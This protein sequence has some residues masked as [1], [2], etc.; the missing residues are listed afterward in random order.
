M[1]IKLIIIL[2][3]GLTLIYIIDYEFLE[4]FCTAKHTG[5]R[6]Y[7]WG[8]AKHKNY[9]KDCNSYFVDYYKVDDTRCIITKQGYNKGMETNPITTTDKNIKQ[10]SWKTVRCLNESGNANADCKIWQPSDPGN[11]SIWDCEEF[12]NGSSN[13]SKSFGNINS[14]TNCHNLGGKNNPGCAATYDLN[15]LKSLNELGFSCVL[16]TTGKKIAPTKI[17]SNGEIICVK[18]DD[19]TGCLTFNSETDC[20]NNLF[21]VPN[22]QNPDMVCDTKNKSTACTNLYNDLGLKTLGELTYTTDKNV[23]SGTIPMRLV[24]NLTAVELP[25]YDGL[26]PI[27]TTSQTQWNNTIKDQIPSEELKYIKC[28]YTQNQTDWSPKPTT[29]T[30]STNP[31]ENFIQKPQPVDLSKLIDELKDAIPDI[32]IPGFGSGGG[33]GSGGNTVGRDPT[34]TPSTNK[35]SPKFNSEYSNLCYTIG[36][37]FGLFPSS[38]QMVIKAKNLNQGITSAFTS[39]QDLNNFA[40]RSDM[41]NLFGTSDTDEPSEI[42]AKIESILNKYPLQ[43]YCCILPDTGS[44]KLNI[45]VPLDPTK[46]YSK[47][48]YDFSSYGS[49]LQTIDVDPKVCDGTGY[50][51]YGIDGKGSMPSGSCDDF[52]KVNCANIIQ[53]LKN[54]KLDTL[55]NIL[56]YAP[57]CACF[58]PSTYYS[59]EDQLIYQNVSSKCWK[60]G[61]KD[62]QGGGYYDRDS[63]NAGDCTAVICANFITNFNTINSENFN[64]YSSMVNECGVNTSTS[65]DNT[66]SGTPSDKT[67]TPSATTTPSDTKTP[68]DTSSDTKT[69]SDT[70]SDTK[71]TSDTTSDTKTSSDTKTPSDTSSDTKTPSDNTSGTTTSGSNLS[72][73]SGSSG[74]DK[75]AGLDSTIFYIVIGL[76]GLVV[77][78]SSVFALTQSKGRR[79]Y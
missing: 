40:L 45:R 43:K 18:T 75:I 67:D 72:G 8:K 73:S 10:M 26:N 22:N 76:V 74:S 62:S 6:Y 35:S 65:A 78:L 77:I 1:N 60:K 7:D 66:P 53:Y 34:T 31:A 69:P 16:G 21:R 51:A 42:K 50:K 63:L 37:E 52:M 79:R 30:N 2:L 41:A 27:K 13:S 5:A 12:R 24:D 56:Q 28:S 44:T 38:D 47:S 68:S 23:V 48:I 70:S 25:S 36:K 15:G 54:K 29:T 20:Q 32:N 46:D 14:Y 49:D 11:N 33:S 39:N 3:I 4:F 19:N 58:V 17:G 71:T 61:C 64:D 57:E 55:E 9:P 59:K